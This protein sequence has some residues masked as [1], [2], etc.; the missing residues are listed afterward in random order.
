MSLPYKTRF[1][2]PLEFLT[3]QDWN[4]FV[5]NLLFIDKYGSARLLQYYQNGNLQN[6]NE[7]IAK[8]L[9]VSALKIAEYNVLHN[10][11]QPQ[12]YTFGEGNQQPFE[13]MSQRPTVQFN[14][15]IPFKFIQFYPISKLPNYQFPIFPVEKLKVQLSQV[16]KQLQLLIPKIVSK[17]ITP[18]QIAGTQ[19]QFSGSA[20][21]EQLVENYLDS[22]Y[23][24][25]WR[26]IIIQ[27]LGNS[28]VQINNSIYLMPK[29]CLK[30]TAS[31]PSEIQLTAQTPTLLSEEIEFTGIPTIA[32]TITI[33]NNQSDPTP[34]PFQQLLQLNLSSI[35]SSPNQLLNLQFCLDAQCKTPLYAWI[36]QYNS[37]LSIVY[38]WV[39]LPTSIPANGSLTIYMF[40]RNT[41]QFP[42]T[43]IN[44]YYNTAYDNGSY[45]FDA[46]INA[47]GTS[48]LPSNLQIYSNVYSSIQFTP[49]SGTT[50]GYILMLDNQNGSYTVIYLDSTNA[51]NVNEIFESVEY[52]SGSADQQAIEFLGS[53]SFCNNTS[54]GNAQFLDNGYAVS[55]DPYDGQAYIWSGCT[56]EVFSSENVFTSS[57]YNFYQAIVTSLGIKYYGQTISSP[58]VDLPQ[59]NLQQIV[60]W[61]ST[62]T[63][64]GSAFAIMDD[65]GGAKHIGYFYWTR[66][67][68][69]PPNNVM[70]SNSQP[71]KTIILIQ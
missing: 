28:P 20:T 42:Y 37:N 40:I 57:G 38:I 24:Q 16:S 36:S 2:L 52:Y 4:N 32:Y 15:Q 51:N 23:L 11:S 30:I 69:L 41:N 50:P 8:Y 13:S 10:F 35:L 48:Y 47:M 65:S 43:G 9:Y 27:N 33:T 56:I 19:F 44:A 59:L 63:P 31:S 14:Y 12:A 58:I 53:A 39:L 25:T 7:V 29:Q 1:K 62:I 49:Q 18:S 67:R 54:H 55:W 3:L 17:I 60:T 71:Q 6:L 21:I 68:K 45:V 34:S 70:P 46:Y 64:N 61:S 66:A 5:K 26:E 22:L